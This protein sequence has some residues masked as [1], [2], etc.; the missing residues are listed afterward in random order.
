M[1]DTLKTVV[2]HLPE[3]KPRHLLG[4][5]RIKDIFIAVENGIDLF[6]CVIPTREARHGRIWTN[7]G[8]YDIRKS[9]YHNNKSRLESICTCPA[10]KKFTRGQI[11]EWF[12]TKNPL[13]GRYASIHNIWFFNSLLEKIR[14]SIKAVPGSSFSSVTLGSSATALSATTSWCLCLR[15][16]KT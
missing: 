10:C 13:A 16:E 3:E 1:A 14:A 15:L 4:I 6:D 9:I 8:A 2:P 5:G 12:K 11:H 7:K